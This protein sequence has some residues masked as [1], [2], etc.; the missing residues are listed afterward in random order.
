MHLIYNILHRNLNECGINKRAKLLDVGCG[1]GDLVNFMREEDYDAFGIDIEFKEGEYKETLIS[2]EL[3]KKIDIGDYNR[4]TF[5]SIQ[6]YVWPDFKFLFDVLVSKAVLEHVQNLEEFAKSS[7]S[8]L[9]DGGICI[10]YFPS[11]FSFIEPHIGVPFGGVFINKM[12]ISI[13][14]SLG[15]C[16]DTYRGNGDKAYNYMI[17]FTSYRKQSQIDMIFKEAGF[18]RI[19]S[20]GPLQCHPNLLFNF[21]GFFPFINYF[22]S[23]FRSR[24]VIYKLI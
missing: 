11:K 10:H 19:K 9:K 1:N 22:F 13:M 21:L 3:I 12:W 16:F 4:A 17:N 14:C 5:D 24:V 6:K 23:I 18:R 20:I 15:L 7:R 2:Q 8:I